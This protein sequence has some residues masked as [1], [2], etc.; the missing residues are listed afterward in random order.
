MTVLERCREARAAATA[1]SPPSSTAANAQSGRELQQVPLRDGRF[2]ELQEARRAS[3]RRHRAAPARNR[4]SPRSCRC[5]TTSSARL[6]SR[7]PTDCAA[8]CRRRC[9][10][11]SRRSRAKASKP[12][13]S[14]AAVRSAA[15]RSD[16]DAARARRRRRGHRPRRGPQGVHDGRRGAAP[17]ASRRRQER[18]NYKD[19]YAI[20]GVPKSA[21]EK[22]IKSAYR[23]LARKWHPDAEPGQ[24]A[25]GRREVQGHPGGVRGSRRSREAPQVR[26]PGFGL[27][28]RR[29]RGRAAPLVPPG[30]RRRLRQF[31]RLRQRRRA[32]GGASGFSDF[33]D[34]F[35]SGIGRQPPAGDLRLRRVSSAVR[36]SSRRS[37]SRF[38]KRSRAARNP[39]RCRSRTSCPRCHGTGTDR[40]RIC[41]QCHGVG[42]RARDEAFRRDDPARRE[43]RSAHSLRGSRRDGRRAA[44]RAGSLSRRRTH[45]DD[46]TNA[47]ATISTSIFR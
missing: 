24:P 27:A 33:F 37:S 25:P 6:R 38:T 41:P 42:T 8:G 44:D 1:T 45:D 34:M 32:G 23:K 46:S 21:A 16:R 17:R 31:Q 29:A 13:R 18:V 10:C 14:W 30:A 19:Y 43:R 12:S 22:D 35:F 15:R 26:R 47:K 20:L 11:S 7:T 28:A 40:N 36:I 3:A 2:R 4:C 5:S 9:A 39:S